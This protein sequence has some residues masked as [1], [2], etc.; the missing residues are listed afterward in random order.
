MLRF[1]KKGLPRKA[2]PDTVQR[3]YATITAMA[4]APVFYT[5]FAVPDTT[6]GRYDLLC[7]MLSLFLFR[8]QQ[9][10]P[11]LAQALFDWAFRNTELGLR[12]AGVGDLGVPKHMKRM[13]EGFY[14][15]A[16]AYYEALEQGEN[17]G[18]AVILSRNLYNQ[19]NH[20]TAPA[21]AEWVRIA[22]QFLMQMDA[23]ELLDDPD[24]MIQL[25]PPA[26]E[27]A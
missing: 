13:L 7:L 27:E 19:E 12:E 16:A 3:L 5:R 21:M 1:A 23:R 9:A 15:R 22:S 8:V 26:N 17:Q 10:D 2:D 11:E 14:G 24:A 18:L 20:S 6:D 4:R 25:I